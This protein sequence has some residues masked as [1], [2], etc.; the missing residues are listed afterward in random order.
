MRVF[1]NS[2]ACGPAP[3]VPLRKDGNRQRLLTK[4]ELLRGIP[5]LRGIQY[6]VHPRS[7]AE[8]L[9]TSLAP[10]ARLKPLR[11]PA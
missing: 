3:E 10:A 11:Q 8:P 5:L 7:A 9:S 2:L 1:G 4:G 6:R